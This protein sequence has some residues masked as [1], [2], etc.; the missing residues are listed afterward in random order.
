MKLFTR[1]GLTAVV[2]AAAISLTS[3][4]APPAAFAEETASSS[5]TDKD[6]GNSLKGIVEAIELV[7]RLFGSITKLQGNFDKLFKNAGSS[8]PAGS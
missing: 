5:T 8:A 4:T 6:G 7:A 1:K 3:V 2:A